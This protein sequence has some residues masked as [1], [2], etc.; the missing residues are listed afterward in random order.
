MKKLSLLKMR[1]KQKGRVA[2]I[3]GEKL[4]GRLMS[5]GIYP[6]KEITK[7]SHMALR[8]PVT[9]KVARSVLALGHEMA[10][11]IILETDD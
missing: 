1:E 6:G 8:G 11:K 3:E 4:R 7:L 9:I 2:D 5:M 10:G